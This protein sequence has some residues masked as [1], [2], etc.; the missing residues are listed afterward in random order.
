MHGQQN[1][2]ICTERVRKNFFWRVAEF[3]VL[4]TSAR[5]SQSTQRNLSYLVHVNTER[6]AN[7]SDMQCFCTLPCLSS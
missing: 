4:L 6:Q 2:K 1:I 7:D 3:D 5:N